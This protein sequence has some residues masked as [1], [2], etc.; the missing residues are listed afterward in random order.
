MYE[1]ICGFTSD[2]QAPSC[3]SCLPTETSNL[4]DLNYGISNLEN[5]KT[6]RNKTIIFLKFCFEYILAGMK[7]KLD[8][9]G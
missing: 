8:E 3:N 1:N 5:L 6:I 7:L 4:L 9:S 2:K